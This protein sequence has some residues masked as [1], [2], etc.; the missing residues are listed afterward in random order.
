MAKTIVGLFDDSSEAQRVAQ[1]L[2]EN[3]FTRDDVFVTTDPEYIGR[4]AQAVNDT[5]ATEIY[6]ENVRRGG[7][8]VAVQTTDD[9]ARQAGDLIAQ[10]NLVDLEARSAE[11]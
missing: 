5:A 10:Y 1:A 6:T 3:G 7:T 4:L 2:L 9:R 11:Y 8:V